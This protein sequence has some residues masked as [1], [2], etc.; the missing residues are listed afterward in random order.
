MRVMWG[1]NDEI[2]AAAGAHAFA[3]DLPG[4]RVELLDGGHWLLE[5]HL[6]EAAHIIVD[7]L[8][9]VPL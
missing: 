5:S 9:D 8:R 6:T 7:F 4:A 3:R 2:F 1:K